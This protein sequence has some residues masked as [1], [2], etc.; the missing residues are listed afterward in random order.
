MKLNPPSDD[1]VV[2]TG[3]DVDTATEGIAPEVGFSF[4]DAVVDPILK[5]NPPDVLLAG[6]PFVNPNGLG[7][8]CGPNSASW[9]DPNG[10][11]KDVGEDIGTGTT[12][13]E[14]VG[15]AGRPNADDGDGAPYGVNTFS[16]ATPKGVGAPFDNRL[17]PADITILL[18]T[19]DD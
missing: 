19:L 6:F 18:L 9:G 11:L 4:R 10:G 8:V 16:F 5:L 12:T 13:G 17:S 7:A 3:A 2:G 14:D 1:F 15:T